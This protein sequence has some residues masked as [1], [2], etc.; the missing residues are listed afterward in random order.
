MASV[1]SQTPTYPYPSTLNVGNFVTLKLK[2]TN[3]LLWKTQIMG[4]IQSQDMM[5]F[6]DGSLPIPEE[7]VEASLAEVAAVKDMVINPKYLAWRKSDCLLRAWITGT[8]SEETLGIVVEL[9]TSAEVWKALFDAFAQST[10]EREFALEQKLRR[11]HKNNHTM[12]EYIQKFKEICD[13]FSA[14]GKPINDKDKVFSL[15][16]GLGHEYESFVTTMLKPPRPTY[17][18]DLVHFDSH[19]YLRR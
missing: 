12:A 1:A 6:V 11:H 5:G 2:Q 9:D 8:L 19:N 10:Q 3:F 18:E 4:L 14:I 15:L 7:Y 13:E 16:T 17:T